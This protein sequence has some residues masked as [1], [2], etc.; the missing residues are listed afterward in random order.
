MFT[1]VSGVERPGNP[2]CSGKCP[3][4]LGLGQAVRLGM[5]PR[6]PAGQPPTFVDDQ[7]PVRR[8]HSQQLADQSPPTAP[9][10]HAY[11]MFPVSLEVGSRPR[12][13]NHS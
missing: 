8:D 2:E 9:D 5:Q 10:A 3:A 6:S 11:R 7:P 12:P 1:N 4:P 13:L